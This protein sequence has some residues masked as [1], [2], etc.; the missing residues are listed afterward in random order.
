MVERVSVALRL[1]LT[2][3]EDFERCQ[4]TP[5]YRRWDL[6]DWEL[7]DETRGKDDLVVQVALQLVRVPFS[8]TTRQLQCEILAPYLRKKTFC[9]ATPRDLWAFAWTYPTWQQ[10]HL[11]TSIFPNNR[12]EVLTLG[13]D[14][15]TR[16]INVSRDTGGR[17][18]PEPLRWFAFREK[19]THVQAVIPQDRTRIPRGATTPMRRSPRLGFGQH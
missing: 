17:W 5:L 7:F 12:S 6:R 4:L 11:V 19:F 15:S 14:A 1:D 8:V 9:P 10:H 18:E 3:T 2:F 13:G 16:T